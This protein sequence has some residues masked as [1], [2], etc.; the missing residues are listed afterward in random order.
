MAKLF[1]DLYKSLILLSRWRVLSVNFYFVFHD[2]S[3]FVE[4][5]STRNPFKRLEE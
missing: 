1:F 5:M 4:N 2:N 3:M